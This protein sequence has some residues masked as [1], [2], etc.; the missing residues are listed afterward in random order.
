MTDTIVTFAIVN[1]NTCERLRACLNS[2]A[3]HV[4]LPHQILVADNASTD[5]SVPML[6]REF[7]KVDLIKCNRNLGFAGAHNLLIPLSKGKYH[8]LVNSDVIIKPR[9][10]ETIVRR[11]E[12]EPDIAVAGCRIVGPD[13]LLQPSCRRFPSLWQQLLLATGL[14]RLAPR[15]RLWNGYLMGDFDHATSRDVDQVMGSIF[16][17]RRTD[18]D[19][20]GFLDT[21]YFMYFEEVDF[22]KRVKQAGKRVFFEADAEVWHEGGGSSRQVRVLTIRRTMRSMRHYFHKHYGAWT[23]L[24]LL[25]IVS[26]DGVTH[27]LHACVTSRNAWLTAKDYALG[28]LD[29]MTFRKASF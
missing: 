26:L 4:S 6:E 5:E 9:A 14:N 16:A 22:C 8:F 18:C 17:M 12:A 24:P 28:F 2:I 13:G 7:P 3:V 29:V 15:S 21:D 25:A 10:I 11:M 1:W 23:W 27:T 19:E 20:L